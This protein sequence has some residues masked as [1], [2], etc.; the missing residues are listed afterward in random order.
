MYPLVPGEQPDH[1]RRLM[2]IIGC[3]DGRKE[4]RHAGQN[5]AM[6]LKATDV[7]GARR[8]EMRAQVLS[9]INSVTLK[10]SLHLS[11]TVSSVERL[12]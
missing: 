9:L 6:V 3:L 11:G 12:H 2:G 10:L 5:K 7:I 4:E 8:E 1:Y